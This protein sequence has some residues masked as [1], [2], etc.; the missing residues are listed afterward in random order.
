MNEVDHFLWNL[1]KLVTTNDKLS[2]LGDT[3][4]F[5]NEEIKAV[6]DEHKQSIWEGAYQVLQNWK[7]R[8]CKQAILDELRPALKQCQMGSVLQEIEHENWLKG[9]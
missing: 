4:N 2:Q 9:S 3:L 5:M 7:M 8:I 1:T 6:Q